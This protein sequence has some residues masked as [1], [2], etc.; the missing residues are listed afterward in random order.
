MEYIP[1]N[2]NA[3]VINE[4]EQDRIGRLHKRKEK[5]LENSDKEESNE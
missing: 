2:Y 5:E 1:D 4:S 3:F